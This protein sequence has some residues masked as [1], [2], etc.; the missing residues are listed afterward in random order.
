LQPIRVLLVED[1]KPQRALA[2]LLL[3]KNPDLKLICEAEDGLDAV[4]KAQQFRPDVILMDIGLPKLNGLEAARQICALVP[5]ARII[6]LTQETD[7]DVVKEAFD[8]S[9]WG[10]VLKQAGEG[11]LFAAIAAV[12]AGKRYVSRAL[13]DGG[14]A[15]TKARD[16]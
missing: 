15:P 7:V 6:F 8:L 3:S 1:F 11:E 14:A 4:V 5:S 2:A 9:A 13:D 16:D 12:T 10:Y